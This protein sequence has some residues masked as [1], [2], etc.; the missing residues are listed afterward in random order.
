MNKPISIVLAVAGI[1]VIGLGLVYLGLVLGRYGWFPQIGPSRAY[2]MPGYSMMDQDDFETSPCGYGMMGGS[3]MGYGMM[4][5]C[6]YD[7][8]EAVEPLSISEAEDAVH[9]YLEGFQDDDLVLDEIMIFS[10]HAYAE[11]VE[12]STGV[13]AM[14][15][16]VDPVTLAVFPEYGPNMMWNL[17]Y[18]HMGGSGGYGRGGMMSGHGMM[19]AGTPNLSADDAEDMPLSADEAVTIAQMYLD[20]YYPGIQVDEHADRFYGYYTLHTLQD[21]EVTGM[22]S[23]NGFSGQVFLHAWHGEFIEMSEEH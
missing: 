20:R 3:G 13:G 18:G 16:L 4:E 1:L 22:L 6:P 5:D 8:G 7:T 21:G 19:G 12:K 23:V 17:K 2:G 10:N 11:I 15:V 9:E 14:E